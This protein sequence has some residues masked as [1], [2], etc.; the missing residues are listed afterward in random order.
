STPD[1][2]GLFGYTWTSTVKNL[3]VTNATIVGQNYLGVIAGQFYGVGSDL[4]A[5]GAVTGQYQVG[6]LMGTAE[7]PLSD[8]FTGSLTR[9]YSNVKV[10]GT[11]S[12]VGGLV[13]AL[14]EDLTQ[15]YS[16]GYV[17]GTNSFVGGLVGY[18]Q[19]GCNCSVTYG[20]YDNLTSGKAGAGTS[21]TTTQLQSALPTG[22]DSA[23][24]GL[25]QGQSYPYLKAYYSGTPQ[26]V[27]G[28]AYSNTGGTAAA[29]SLVTAMVNGTQAGSIYAGANGY[30]N[31]LLQAGTIGANSQLAAYTTGANAGVTYLQNASGTTAGFTI[32]G[33][34]LT[35]TGS[36]STLSAISSGLATALGSSG[37][38]TNLANLRLNATSASF[39]IDQAINVTGS[40][41][42]FAGGTV[43]QSAGASI[44]AA[45]VFLAP[46]NT[47]ASFTL[48]DAGNAIGNL[49]GAS[50]GS[51]SLDFYS[52][53]N[54]SVG[55]VTA[56]AGMTIRSGGALT[57]AG[58]YNSTATGNAVVFAGTT[59]KNSSFA[60]AITTPN[61][62]WLV[63]SDSP[64]GD[65]F[66]NLNS[67][68]D[69]IWNTVYAAGSPSQI[70]SGNRYVF[71]YQPTLTFT[72]TNASK[73]YGSSADVS[74]N[75]AVTSD[76]STLTN[77]YTVGSLSSLYTGAPALTSAGTSATATVAGGPY[78]ISIGQ[79]SVVAAGPYAL[80]F[81]SGGSLT[82]NKSSLIIYVGNANKTYGDTYTGSSSDYSVSGL[83]NSDSVSSVT[84]T[85]AGAAATANAGSYTLTGS[86]AAGTGLSNYN[87][88][89]S[90]GTL[91]V[92]KAVLTI[93]AANGTKTYGAN[94]TFAGT[95]FAY[96]GLKNSDG[97][98]SVALSSA[99][100][101]G[102]ANVGNYQIAASGAAGSGLSNYLIYYNTGSLSV[103]Q[104]PI[105]ITANDQSKVY[106]TTAVLGTTA[107]SVTGS[108]FNGDQITGVTLTSGAT[109]AAVAV[110]SQAIVPSNAAGTGL[111]NYSITYS[112]AGKLTVSPAQLTITANDQTKTY[113]TV[114]G[115]NGQYSIT[116]GSLFNGDT[117]TGVTLASAGF[118]G[119]ATV[120]GGPYAITASNAIGNGLYN[121][122]I[123][124]VP[125]SLTVNK[126]NLTVTA[127]GQS[128]F[129]GDTLALDPTKFSYGQL[130]NGDT[131]SAV[132][133]ASDG[134]AATAVAGAHAIT[135]SNAQGTG[136][137]NYNITYV[138]GALTVNKAS[139]IV[140]VGNAY[141]GYGNTYTGSVNDYSI[142]GLKNADSV[143][144]VTLSS[145]G[146]AATANAGNYTLA[147][148]NAQGTGLSNY[149]VMYS[150]GS[151][152]VSK[153]ILTITAANGTKVYGTDKVFSGTEF[154]VT[155]LKNSDAVSSVA[156]SSSGAVATANVGSYQIAAANAAGS[157][158]S[159]YLIYY[160]T[161]SL[162]VTAAPI[163]VT[164]NDQAKTYGSTYNLGTTAFSITS[165]ALVNGDAITGV[166]LTSG[167]AAATA[168]AGWQTIYASNAT[169]TGLSNYAVTYGT[170]GKLTVNPAPLTITAND[171]TKTYG[172]V[173]GSN[174]QYAITNGTLFN[175]DTLAGVTLTSA[176]FAGSA[177]VAGGPYAITAG[178]ATGN[179][180]YNYAIT[181]VPGALTVNKASLTVTAADQS[182]TY[183]NTANL[184]TSAYTLTG[185]LYNGDNVS[186]VTLTSAGIGATATVAGG[187]YAITASNAQGS[188]LG[189]Y[190]ISYVDGALTVNKASLIV[191]AG[192][193]TKSYGT[194]YSS[195]SDYA[196]S[197]LKNSDSVTA[198][199]LASAGAAAGANVGNYALNA[200]DA[201]GTGL[202]NY[203]VS[204][205]AGTL[206]V[207]PAILTIVAANGT[208]VYGAT[209]S[210]AGSEFTSTG[211]V[212][213]DS[214]ASV[215]LTSA[216]TA[217]TANVG[218]Y[219][220]TAANATGS[221]LSNYL[222]YY[223]QG[224]LSVTPAALT[225]T[226]GNQSKVYGGTANLGS[227]AFSITSGA[228]FNNDAITDVTLTSPGGAPATANV[229]GYSLFA[230]SAS[231]TGV[232]NYN[233]TYLPGTLSVTPAPLTVTAGNQSK[234]YGDTLNLG[235]SAFTTTGS[236]FNGDTITGVTSA[237]AGA[238]A[239]AGVS[240]G[241]YAIVPSNAQGSGLS[242]YA[243]TYV[244]GALTVDKAAVTVTANNAT[245]GY[246]QTLT[247]NG[248]EFTASGLKNGETI[249]SV[250]LSSAGTAATAD[251]NGSPYAIVAS[252]ASGGTFNSGNYNITYVSGALT[253]TPAALTV[254]ITPNAATKVYGNALNFA[255]T[256]FSQVGL[257]NGDTISSVTLTSAGTAATATVGQ[258]DI[259]SSNAVFGSGSA[260]NYNITYNV[261]ANGLTVTP[262]PLLITAN[263]VS[264]VYGDVNPT[265]GTATG[266]NLVNGDAITGVTLSSTA[267]ATSGVGSYGLT[268]SNATGNGLS[269]YAITYATAAN[270][271]TV[272]PRA[273]VITANSVSRVYGDANPTAGTATGDNLVNGDSIIGVSLSSPATTASGVG[274][275]SLVGSNA[276]GN[277]LSN[278]TITYATGANGL[279]VT[280]RALV[281]TANSVSRVYGDVNPTAGT[282]TGDNLVNGDTITGVSLSSPATMASGVGG[283]ALTGSNATGN[284]LS[285]YAITYATVAN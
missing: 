62:R 109:G 148:S 43:T 210:F 127:G 273:L 61:G 236:L 179:G 81:V 90:A 197:G 230:S 119:S 18:I 278:Y 235:N 154:T 145:A 12:E 238:G 114:L 54:L 84:L 19:S 99:G 195:T 130:Y 64:S 69:A 231:G 187:P 186:G 222:I 209:G 247:F 108:M 262:R 196:V 245:K 34:M 4:F 199:T 2:V 96:S 261:L 72:S 131:L 3:G 152:T 224:S 57:I 200:S 225:I 207:S 47:N 122:T 241:P 59:F 272:T 244:N 111:S 7:D 167:A 213:G 256:E 14:G 106:G 89:Y 132:T 155:G 9:V 218:N 267:S 140:Y 26:A 202:G 35:E 226:A 227:T 143:S 67:N 266:N 71:A 85:S 198:V 118:A 251:V 147:G 176:G 146:A 76:V 6:G 32:F 221:G 120:A 117:L 110:G 234:I 260:L 257:V 115:S 185:N 255:G 135:A 239:N 45:S 206:N 17:S 171:Q 37:V 97:V 79:G 276:T 268:G 178:N 100:A 271:L 124:Y 49:Q 58:L 56:N 161:G 74:S 156:L 139:L 217:A 281:I 283:Y 102:T 214:I 219:W 8:G 252:T 16:S 53:T 170:S 136:L 141:K 220:I 52:G 263:N 41:Y 192:N 40:A 78:A 205:Q 23:Y 104:A 212:N 165:G 86:N 39:T 5:T 233:I 48:N 242:N 51:G 208:K 44:T 184:G 211:L 264:R 254:T 101:A 138:D 203:I 277:G 91:T 215:Q 55:S 92:G 121:Y 163:T 31:I 20:Y 82:V 133:L 134:T 232:S 175:G 10:V 15:A 75:Y 24:W 285:N 13:G 98:S 83:Y 270:G 113:G 243:I 216:G 22:F 42:I 259:A 144:S 142:S 173:L 280:P 25:V 94:L 279:T 282:A 194:T 112:Q 269:N 123:T 159:N 162:N 28:W 1:Q 248:T 30:Y 174:G 190:N 46:Q 80:N 125:G 250:A 169:G 204:Y 182:K 149:N 151:L 274:S 258:Y 27:S 38:S 166:T 237:S 249:G 150:D 183:G 172:T 36:S 128:K 275:Y 181:Y 95:E 168:A 68:N 93:T 284:G 153:A 87:V 189:N 29:G 107:Y 160:N 228:L 105:T 33:T 223:N 265:T 60:N 164:A 65:S 63:Y 21:Y 157:G 193:K 177:T 116:S 77:V 11:G 88:L 50:L 103:T 158:L 253:V 246:G 70:A 137:G 129:Y 66:N 180:L 191:Y 229:A 126:A 188:G 240:G 201:Q 73:Y